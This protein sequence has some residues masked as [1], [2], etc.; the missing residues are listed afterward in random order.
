MTPRRERLSRHHRL[1]VSSPN[2]PR[3][4]RGTR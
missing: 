1:S 4:C 2:E 3:A